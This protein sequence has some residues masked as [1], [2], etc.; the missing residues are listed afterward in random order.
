MV[1]KKIN[2]QRG[3]VSLFVVI[4]AALLITVVTVSFI[5]LMILN[6]Q[7]ATANNLS[8]SAYDSAQA[9]VEDGK[10]AILSFMEGCSKSD[11]NCSRETINTYEKTCN[12]S[13]QA[14]SD[15]NTIPNNDK[16]VPVQ[17]GNVS[18][19]QAYTCVKV[20]MLTED[21]VGL[22]DKDVVSV[23]PLV[24][25]T[26]FDT[27]KIEWF[28]GSDLK[29]SSNSTNIDY[30]STTIDTPLLSES[31][32]TGVDDPTKPNIPS[33][34]RTQLIQF[35]KKAGEGFKLSD[36]D[37][38]NSVNALNNTL[39]LYPSSTVG[40]T[41]FIDNTRLAN[42]SLYAPSKKNCSSNIASGS[43]ACSA[44]LKLPNPVG[45]D[46]VAYLNLRS[47]YK[48]SHYRITLSDSASLL[49]VKFDKVQPAIDSTG[50]ADDLFRRVQA[51]V[52]LT[53]GFPYPN[54]EIQLKGNLCK[55]F[56]VT[57]LETDFTDINPGLCTP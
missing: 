52:S 39:F 13:V 45:T 57:N 27:I 48:S 8:Q 9:G 54:G 2:K 29:S 24:G 47:L 3:A 17:T 1:M 56:I 42:S 25:V 18:L 44:D 41:T 49:P 15:V 4:F 51:R 31:S 37:S 23:I 20:Q 55:D 46:Y 33:I 22:L 14:L 16:E 6:Q 12:A 28:N 40:L 26:P 38:E 32:W 35:N 50:R 10:R 53:A 11:P 7:Q 5:R 21:V 19:N 30:P 34:M 36:F 43:Y